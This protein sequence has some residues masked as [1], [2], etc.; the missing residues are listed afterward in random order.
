[1][2]AHAIEMLAGGKPLPGGKDR[3]LGQ[4]DDDP[5]DFGVVRANVTKV[6]EAS[7]T[8]TGGCVR[9]SYS[10]IFGTVYPMAGVQPTRVGLKSSSRPASMFS[11]T[12]SA[13]THAAQPSPQV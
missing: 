4:L 10:Q 11:S 5:G 7:I 6:F 8:A 9:L 12:C 13:G 2:V 1:M 3:K